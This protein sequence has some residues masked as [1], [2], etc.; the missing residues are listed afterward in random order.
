MFIPAVQRDGM[1]LNLVSMELYNLDEL[2][3]GEQY[4]GDLYGFSA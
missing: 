4:P 3:S 1:Y 2:V